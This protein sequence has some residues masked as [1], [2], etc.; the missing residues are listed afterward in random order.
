MKKISLNIDPHFTPFRRSM[1]CNDFGIT[2]FSFPSGCER[3]IKI[4]GGLPPDYP[5]VITTRI[6]SSD[7]IIDFIFTVDALR[8]YGI[9]KIKAFI[10]YLPFA[11]QDRIM[12]PGEPFSLKVFTNIINSLELDEVMVYDPHSDVSAALLNKCVVMKNY[13]FV[14]KCLANKHDYHIVSPDA[15]AYKKIFDVCE[16]IGYKSDIILCNKVRDVSTGKIKKLSIDTQDLQGKDCYIIDDICDGGGTFVLLAQ[17]LRKHNCGKINLIVS[18]GIFSKGID[19]IE[20]IDHIYT[21]DSV[22]DFTHEKVTQIK[23][24]DILI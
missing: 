23:L 19:A 2:K 6:K 9:K 20:G 5:V 16:A 22:Q 1:S 24:C 18:H 14:A 3:H 15:G 21:T 13:I 7:D 10:P 17:E 4:Q 8:R 11:R 12:V